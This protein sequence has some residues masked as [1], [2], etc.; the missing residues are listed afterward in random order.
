[1]TAW[2]RWYADSAVATLG[3]QVGVLRGLGFAGDVH[4]PVAGRGALPADLAEAVAQ[5]FGGTGPDGALGRG[6]DYPRQF[7][8]LARLD[9]AGTG[10]VVID[11]TG[12]DDV[13]A[14]RARALDPPQDS[15]PC[16]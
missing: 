8:A 2:F 16:R 15:L 11:F 3:W 14:V 5:R 6:L 1:M 12:L 4:L 7:A 13:S 9:R 10:R